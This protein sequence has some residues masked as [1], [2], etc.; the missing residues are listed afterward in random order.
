MSCAATGGLTWFF[1]GANSSQAGKAVPIGGASTVP[2]SAATTGT[3]TTVSAASTPTAGATPTTLAPAPTTAGPASST[4]AAASP[5]AQVFDGSAIDTKY[6]PV[7]VE[8]Q[9]T[10]G[11]LTDVIVTEY[12]ND[13]GR[14]IRI[15]QGALPVLNTEALQAQ[16]SHVDTVSGATYTSVAYTQS[17]QSAIDAARTAGA[18]T[19]A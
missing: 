11:K 5:D 2:A 1:A 13:R 17:L 6:G 4:P 9:I 7:Q 15:N 10:A 8:A 18:T 12:P 16:S 3:P 14:S 19:L